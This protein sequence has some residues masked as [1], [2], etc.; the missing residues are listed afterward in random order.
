MSYLDRF[1]DLL[2]SLPD[3]IIYF[4]LAL[5]A[6][7]E[8]I[9]PPAPGDMITA[10]G[11]FLVGTKRL[12]FLGVYVSTIIGSVSGFLFLFWIGRVLGRRFFIERGIWFFKA[13]D[14]IRAEEWF[15]KYGH[16]LVLLNRFLPGIRS[17]ISI[18]CGISGLRTLRVAFLAF[19]S[20]C[21]WNLIW[22]SLGYMLGTN[23]ETVRQRMV[24]ILAYYNIAIL[25]LLGL[26]I[27]FF[28]AKWLMKGNLQS[29]S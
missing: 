13:Q 24:Q 1:L 3:H 12:H 17:V 20:S 10:F 4:L 15:R 18:V 21:A 26:I 7:V 9:F 2:N 11:A 22:I 6:F 19:L 25:I 23:W 14:I 28:L 8:N 16:F 27:L 29:G 5:S